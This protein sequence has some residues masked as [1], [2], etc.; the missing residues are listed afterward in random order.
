MRTTVTLDA[1][2]EQIIRQ[3]MNEH[4]ISFKQALNDLVREGRASIDGPPEFRTT[5][6]SM[7]LPTV[8]L[9]KALQIAGKLED[10]ELLRRMEIGS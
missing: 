8:D 3:R 9:D 7:G 1:D 4:R 6:R 2:T 5:T 10:D